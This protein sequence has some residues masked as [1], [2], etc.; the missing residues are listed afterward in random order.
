M[1]MSKKEALIASILALTLFSS[2]TFVFAPK[3][4][5]PGQNLLVL[6]QELQYQVTDLQTRVSDLETLS[7]T[8]QGQIGA[9]QSEVSVLQ[10]QIE[11]A[12][13]VEPDYDSGWQTIEPGG[14]LTL[15]WNEL[16]PG[17]AENSFVY[18]TG[19][20]PKGVHHYNYGMDNWYTEEGYK[21]IGMK[22]RILDSSVTVWRGSEDQAWQEVRVR[23]WDLRVPLP[24]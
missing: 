19:R 16:P 20:M 13:L 6:I 9:L 17:I 15:F 4:D 14:Y 7:T 11:R 22:W 2:I 3:P 5:E 21:S 12:L 1:K 24:E 23:I 18:V 10:S 8:Q